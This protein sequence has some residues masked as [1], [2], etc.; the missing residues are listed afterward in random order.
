MDLYSGNH[1]ELG[2]LLKW[3]ENQTRTGLESAGL[4][5]RATCSC[6]IGPGSTREIWL[7]FESQ[8]SLCNLVFASGRIISLL[9]GYEQQQLFPV[10]LSSH[11][12]PIWVH[13]QE[14]VGKYQGKSLLPQPM[15]AAERRTALHQLVSPGTLSLSMYNLWG[16]EE[17]YCTDLI[18]P[19]RM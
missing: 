10:P 4:R 17:E 12:L 5:Y 14:E 2:S 13:L 7:V 15:G 16:E 9:S 3:K 19:P 18:R 1:V 6:A 8:K 11:H